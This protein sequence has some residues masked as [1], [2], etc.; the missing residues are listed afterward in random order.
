MENR[1]V[2]FFLYELFSTKSTE[3]WI[4]LTRIFYFDFADSELVHEM[5]PGSNKKKKVF[6]SSIRK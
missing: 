3:N 5:D 4:C 1:R 6:E 2:L